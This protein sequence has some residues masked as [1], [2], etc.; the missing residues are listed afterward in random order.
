MANDNLRLAAQAVLDE[1]PFTEDCSCL[2]CRVMRD[3]RTVLS[4][5]DSMQ[6]EL[7]RLRGA[8]QMIAEGVHPALVPPMTPQEIAASAL[9]GVTGKT[10]ANLNAECPGCGQRYEAIK[11]HVCPAGEPSHE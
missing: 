5:S 2:G 1:K 8:L 4:S 9:A 6:S 10:P 11:G 3:L 7:D